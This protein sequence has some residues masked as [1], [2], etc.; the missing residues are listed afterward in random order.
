MM[1]KCKI[2]ASFVDK[3]RILWYYD[4]E[5]Y[6]RRGKKLAM[7]QTLCRTGEWPFQQGNAP[8]VFK[9][10]WY[11]E[12][13]AHFCDMADERRRRCLLYCEGNLFSS[14]I[15][16]SSSPQAPVYILTW[17]INDDRESLPLECIH[18]S[19][20]TSIKKEQAHFPSSV[21]HADYFG[22]EAA[23]ARK[24]AKSKSNGLLPHTHHFLSSLSFTSRRRPHTVWAARKGGGEDDG[25][26]PMVNFSA[27][28]EV[29]R[30][31]M[32]YVWM[33]A[34]DPLSKSEVS[35]SGF[36]Q[37]LPASKINLQL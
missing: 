7:I 35:L 21:I 28:L 1:W 10:P 13:C 36:C 37:H 5:F 6:A 23:R 31:R 12:T 30:E 19:P 27:K 14:G 9:V 24:T 18:T 4:G 25:A 17:F 15:S 3:V 2:Q 8:H 20:P 11:K 22:I 34:G 29:R 26:S 33:Y 32:L 16:S